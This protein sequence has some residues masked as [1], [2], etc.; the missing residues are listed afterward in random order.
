M[1]LVLGLVV[2][3]VGVA[4]F[5]VSPRMVRAN[6]AASEPAFGKWNPYRKN[7]ELTRRA[8]LLINRL[9]G[10]FFVV[11]GLLEAVGIIEWL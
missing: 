1:N 6:E 9:V 11:L 4:V 7:A 3:A 10:L 5:F 8:S 2:I